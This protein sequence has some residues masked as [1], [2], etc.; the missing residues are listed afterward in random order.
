[1]DLPGITAITG[2]TGR[3]GSRVARALADAGAQ[4]RLIGR[5]PSKL[6]DDLPGAVAGLPA[7]YADTAAMRATLEGV[8][9]LLL[10]SGR[11]SADRVGD[12]R[13]AIAAAWEAGVQRVV[14]TSFLGAA[15]D[16]TFTF[17]RDHFH[18]EAI[19]EESGMSWVA[20]RNA[21]YQDV[22]PGFAGADGVLRGPAGDGAVAA[23]AVDDVAEAAVAALGDESVRGTVDLSGPAA[24]TL[25]EIAAALTERSGRPVRYERETVEEAYASR[26]HL[27][28]AE[29]EVDG[30]VSTYTAIAAGEMA[31][32]SDGV[33]RLTGH[34]PR[35]LRETLERHPALLDGLRG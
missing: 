13:S 8:D 7:E 31:T 19:L 1:M 25:D 3:I 33:Q 30:W 9:T 10:V 32:V 34:A 23:V 6:P 2:T 22:L 16:C 11:E 21:F 5:D 12:H 18:T 17:G 28:L 4:T 24:L 26:A 20:L 27:G 35:S 14:Y 29:H 15:E